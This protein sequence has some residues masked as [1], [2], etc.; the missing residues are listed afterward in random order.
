MKK[1]RE[2]NERKDSKVLEILKIKDKQIE[3]LQ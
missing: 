1:E 3:E 2:Q